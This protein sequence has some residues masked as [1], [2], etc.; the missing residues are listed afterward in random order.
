M[1]YLLVGDLG[2]TIQYNSWAECHEQVNGFS[3][4]SYTSFP[5]RE[6]AQSAWLRYMARDA[7]FREAQLDGRPLNPEEAHIIDEHVNNNGAITLL[8]LVITLFCVVA[9]LVFLG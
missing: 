8:P 6:D 5:S 2:Y 7:M 1:S 4:S 9:A 3:E